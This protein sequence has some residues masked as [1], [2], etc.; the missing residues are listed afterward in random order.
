MPVDSN[1]QRFLD[2]VVQSGLPPTHAQPLEQARRQMEATSGHLGPPATVHRVVDHRVAVTEGEITVRLYYAIEG[3][4]LPVV[5]YFHGGGWVRGSVETH[6]SYCRSLAHE[7]GVAVASVDYRLAPEHP[8][9]TPVEDAYRAT[10]WVAENASSLV[11]DGRRVAVAGD[12]AG[13]NLAAAVALMARDRS[14]PAL[15]FQALVYPITDFHFDTASYRDFATGYYL[16][17]DDMKW[18]WRQYLG[19]R[20]ADEAIYATVMSSPTFDGLPPA[21][22]VTAE[23]DPLRDEGEAYGRRLGEAGVGCRV[24]RYEGM[25]HGFARR[26][27]IWPAAGEALE[28]VA[29][30]L[31]HAFAMT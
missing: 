18:F 27:G 2:Q 12:S 7:T 23:F 30:A 26:T 19:G 16:T 15:A 29:R 31:R 9:P 25:I 21:L 28:E 22:I 20:S 10:C 11:L 6:D 8:Y 13:G 3:S 4:Q 17:R 24:L 1:V 5:V 14:G